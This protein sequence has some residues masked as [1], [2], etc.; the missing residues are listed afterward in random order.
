MSGPLKVP[1]V[2]LSSLLITSIGVNVYLF[3]V[4]HDD[5]VQSNTIRLDPLGL[6][7]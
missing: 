4:A 6:N 7:A 5:S 1:I 2:L 3:E